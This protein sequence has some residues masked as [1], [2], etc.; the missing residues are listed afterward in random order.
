MFCLFIKMNFNNI[1]RMKYFIKCLFFLVSCVIFIGC[2]KMK[3]TD[4]YYVKYVVESSTIYFGGK[5]NV[6]IN[7][8]NGTFPMLINQNEK[9][10]TTIGPVGRDFKASLKVAKQGW[11]GLSPEYHLKLNLRIEVSKNN[12]PFALRKLN[13]SD[14]PRAVADAEYTIE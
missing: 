5:L 6:Q 11:D 10:E 2:N 8:E 14:S 4:E 12:G 3:L 7:N 1:W 9:W 13:G